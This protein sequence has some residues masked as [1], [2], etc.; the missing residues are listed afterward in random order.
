[1]KHLVQ[2]PKNLEIDAENEALYK[3]RSKHKLMR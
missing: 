2:I 1:M 3:E